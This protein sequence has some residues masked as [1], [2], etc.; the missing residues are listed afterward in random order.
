MKYMKLIKT[1][2]QHYKILKTLI[3]RAGIRIIPLP[4][5]TTL[6][7]RD[8]QVRAADAPPGEDGAILPLPI[9]VVPYVQADGYTVAMR[10]TSSVTVLIGYD[11][12]ACAPIDAVGG[13]PPAGTG[14]V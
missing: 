14:E 11:L 7:G 2:T 10:V 5:I 3:Q 8:T 4:T 12:D 13:L 6:S 1:H 9:D